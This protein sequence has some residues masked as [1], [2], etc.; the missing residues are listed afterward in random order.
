M[1]AN[2]NFPGQLQWRSHEYEGAKEAFGGIVDGSAPENMEAQAFRWFPPSENM[3][4][5]GYL[6]MLAL[7]DNRNGHHINDPRNYLYVHDKVRCFDRWYEAGIPIP[8]YYTWVPGLFQHPA[9]KLPTLLRLN[10]GVAGQDSWLARND[11]EF[12]KYLPIVEDACRAARERGRGVETR[13]LMTQFIDTQRPEH[14]L[15]VSYRIIVAG[16]KVVTGYARVSDPQDW[17]AVTNKFH[18]SIADAWLFYNR[19]CQQI[20]TEHEELIVKAVEVLGLN[21]QGVDI[22]EDGKTGQLYFL[23]VQTTYDAGFIGAG[24]YAPPYYNPYNPELVKFLKENDALIAKELPLYHDVWLDKREH[25]RR[26]YANLAKQFAA[27]A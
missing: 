22:I 12:W 20:M 3:G 9:P 7:R 5:V 4:S 23:E 13:L 24:P 16:G 25:F 19:R 11:E 14:P 26:C 1:L 2:I 21:H 10:N 6:C 17:V 15:N 18:S 27:K 8:N